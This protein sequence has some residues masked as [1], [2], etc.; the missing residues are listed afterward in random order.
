MILTEAYDTLTNIYTNHT[1][2]CNLFGLIIVILLVWFDIIQSIIF[3]FVIFSY[4]CKE[5][6]TLLL[7]EHET[8]KIEDYEYLLKLWSVYS[9]SI[10][11]FNILDRLFIFFPVS[12]IYP[13]IKLAVYILCINDI[14][15]STWIYDTFIVPMF[16]KFHPIILK[17]TELMTYFKI[18]LIHS[19]F[20][21]F[22]DLQNI[23]QTKSII[24]FIKQNINK[25]NKNK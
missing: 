17:L 20:D 5:T 4:L 8:C 19:C 14:N 6:L 1:Q 15:Y 7:I 2:L 13:F 10:I 12:L 22:I 23:I 11:V 18:F 3:N 16:Y 25:F 24:D 21:V 9:L